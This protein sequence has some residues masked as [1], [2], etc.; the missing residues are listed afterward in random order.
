MRRLLTAPNLA[1]ATLWADWL[2]Q[3]GIATRVQRAHAGSIAGELPPDQ[4]QPEL[5][6]DDASRCDEA[7]TMLEAFRH[8]PARHWAC[9]GCGEIID[10]PFEQCWNCGAA[11][12]PVQ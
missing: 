4:A 9:R 5:W 7:R 1:L 6:I 12:P 10:G 2:T 3:A 11:M 8:P